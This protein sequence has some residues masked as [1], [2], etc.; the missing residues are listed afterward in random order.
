MKARR[1]S[2]PSQQNTPPPEQSQ[3]EA[4]EPEVDHSILE[5][6]STAQIRRAAAG[7]ERALRKRDAQA[8]AVSG[9]SQGFV[10]LIAEEFGIS[11]AEA[12]E[13]INEML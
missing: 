1:N 8:A 3:P 11:E 12:Q 13:L 10:Q 4:E 7:V 9:F 5:N 2:R 6:M